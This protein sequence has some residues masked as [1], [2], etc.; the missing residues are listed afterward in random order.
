MSVAL[1]TTR[2]A[3]S[4]LPSTTRSSDP[5]ARR[6]RLALWWQS[7]TERP[8]RHFGVEAAKR[9][10][11]D[12]GGKV[13]PLKCIAPSMSGR[14]H[15]RVSLSARCQAAV[16]ARHRYD[17][18]DVSVGWSTEG[19]EPSGYR[20]RLGHASGR[21]AAQIFQHR[22]RAYGTCTTDGRQLRSRRG[23]HSG[24]S[25]TSLRRVIAG[26]RKLPLACLPP[27]ER[28]LLGQAEISQ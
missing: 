9:C 24:A 6:P 7:T 18:H 11:T 3:G 25:R 17:G 12:R 15:V 10:R 1:S 14:G 23:L 27:Y 13:R 19:V 20:T 8:D 22:R 26:L 2:R 16:H 28:R 5:A 21:G 4:G